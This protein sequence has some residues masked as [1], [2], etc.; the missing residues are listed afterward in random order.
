MRFQGFLT[1]FS[2]E[3]QELLVRFKKISLHQTP[4]NEDKSFNLPPFLE[5][6][7]QLKPLCFSLEFW[8]TPENHSSLTLVVEH[9]GCQNLFVLCHVVMLTTITQRVLP[10]WTSLLR[11]LALLGKSHTATQPLAPCSDMDMRRSRNADCA[12]LFLVSSLQHTV[13][14]KSKK[15]LTSWSK[16]FSLSISSFRLFM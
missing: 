14:Q 7:T 12:R 2:T 5:N 3:L 11:V 9:E 1:I 10:E 15:S 6:V 8:T 13:D 4:Q 16:D